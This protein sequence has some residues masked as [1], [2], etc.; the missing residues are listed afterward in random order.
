MADEN[1]E[2]SPIEQR[3]MEEGWVPQ[4][5]WQGEPDAWRPAKEFL[6]RGELFRKIDELKNENKRIR[7]STEELKKHHDRVKQLAYEEALRDLKKE[8][9]QALQ[10]GDVDRVIEIDDKIAETREKQNKEEVQPQP[11][12]QPQGPAPEFVRWEARNTWYKTDRAMKAV[13]DEIARDLVNRGESDVT[14]ILTEVDKEIRKAFPQKFENPN[15]QKAG[16]VEGT[17]STRPSKEEEVYM[18]DAE[19]RIMNRI[20]ATG[21]DKKKYLEEFKAI[22]SRGE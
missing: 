11:V 21:V 2:V 8:K 18:T 22:R 13:A 16:A 12:A 15:R 1:K 19:K 3:A 17:P 5:E 20:L 9:K 10:D 14:R 7:Q 4:E 6:D